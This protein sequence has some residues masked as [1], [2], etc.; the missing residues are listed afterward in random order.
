MA[1][2][3]SA[4]KP[5]GQ[6]RTRVVPMG[7]S[8]RRISSAGRASEVPKW[9]LSAP[10]PREKV[11]WARLWLVPQSAVWEELGWT[12]AVARYVRILTRA[13]LKK[14]PPIALIEARQAEDRLGLSPMALLRLRWQIVDD[15]ATDQSSSGRADNVI[16]VRKRLSAQ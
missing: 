3:G 2:F 10:S 13:E 6:R 12:D 14:A 9:P 11:L 7:G 15:E 5:E 8:I 1:G 16:D 4:P